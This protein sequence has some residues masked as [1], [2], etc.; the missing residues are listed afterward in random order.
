LET[1][2]ELIAQYRSLIDV[3][4]RDISD[5]QTNGNNNNNNNNNNITDLYDNPI[6]KV[7]N[8]ISNLKQYIDYIINLKEQ[9][10][11]LQYVLDI[12]DMFL[13]FCASLE[14]MIQMLFD[15][16]KIKKYIQFL[17]DIC[18]E[19]NK[20]GTAPNPRSSSVDNVH[21]GGDI[22]N[23]WIQISEYPNIAHSVTMF[24]GSTSEK[25]EA[26]NFI[27]KKKGLNLEQDDVK[28]Q[29]TNI[30]ELIQRYTNLYQTKK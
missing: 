4:H 26:E 30:G 20:V 29:E 21:S 23:K 11:W 7:S 13:V 14:Q 6:N 16:E 28:E 8:E 5:P 19:H 2:K 9:Q 25:I 3:Y 18:V 10:D 1:H 24:S 17:D 27:L 22:I 15:D 12:Q